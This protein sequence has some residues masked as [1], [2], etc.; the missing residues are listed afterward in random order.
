MTKSLVIVLTI[1]ASL[2]GTRSNAQAVAPAVSAND[3]MYA[4]LWQQTAAEYRGASYQTYRA[5]EASLARA[6]KEPSWTAALEQSG[7]F[8]KLPPAIILDLDE[9]VLD[10]SPMQARMIKE[11]KTF[12][13]QEWER[14]VKEARAGVVPG[15]LDF[16]K[17]AHAQGVAAFYVTNRV[18]E[19]AKPDD[20]TVTV[21]RKWNIGVPPERL[22]CR[23]ETGDKSPRRAAVA[24]THRI[25]LLVGDDFND[26][27]S[28]PAE[29]TNVAGRERL[30]EANRSYWGERWFILPNPMY[31]SWERAAGADTKTRYEALRP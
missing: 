31:G 1:H 12:N 20:P 9:T 13:A 30:A 21:L 24:G 19:P 17:A 15:A 18:C 14:W 23:K 11:S 3:T 25:L 16:L 10:N 8:S 2:L 29:M 5:A 22:L 4:V 28:V 26:F 27:I 6:L 7:D